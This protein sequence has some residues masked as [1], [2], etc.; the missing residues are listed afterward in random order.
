LRFRDTDSMASTDITAGG[1]AA[2][3]LDQMRRFDRDRYLAT[4]FAP[5]EPRADLF[6]LYAFNLE[7]ARIREVV[8]EPMMGLIRLQWWRDCVGEIYDGTARR[9]QV[10]QP[11]AWAVER[12]RLPR[13]LLERLIDARE[14]DLDSAPPPDLA[15]LRAYGS[16]TGGTLLELA[17]RITAKGNAPEPEVLQAARDLGTAWALIGLVRAVPFHAQ[18][19]RVYIPQALLDEAGVRLDDLLELRPVPDL[20]RAVARICAEARA[21]LSEAR[22]ALPRP[23]R[24]A[25]PVFLTAVLARRYLADLAGAGHDVFHPALRAAAASTPWPLALAWLRGRVW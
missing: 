1:D 20:S 17:A 13:D 18:A 9:H 22:G 14:A 24:A 8:R 11:L 19:R 15:A 4:L 5:A 25:F 2:Y 23:A 12:H 7:L 6:A 21:L 10:A 16:A 3:C